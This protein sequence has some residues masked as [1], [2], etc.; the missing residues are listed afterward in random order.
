MHDHG[1]ECD[2]DK[3][4]PLYKHGG[5]PRYAKNLLPLYDVLLCSFRCNISPCAGNNDALHGGLVNLL[6][7]SFEVFHNGEMCEENQE[8]D[9]M[10]FN[11]EALYYV[12]MERKSPPYVHMP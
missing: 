6:A 9:V 11:F 12:V 1:V 3:L 8:I 2:K 4:G 10:D 5:V 7:H